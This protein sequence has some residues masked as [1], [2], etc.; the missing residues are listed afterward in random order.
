MV[1]A[2]VANR[3]EVLPG[4]PAVFFLKDMTMQIYDPLAVNSLRGKAQAVVD[5][6]GKK[7]LELLDDSKRAILYKLSVLLDAFSRLYEDV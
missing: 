4:A 5:S 7:D 2:G 1:A 3:D 6:F